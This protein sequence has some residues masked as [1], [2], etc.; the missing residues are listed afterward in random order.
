MQGCV[1]GERC[2]LLN[3]TNNMSDGGASVVKQKALPNRRHKATIQVAGSLKALQHREDALL[4]DSSFR[5]FEGLNSVLS[6]NLI[7][8]ARETTSPC[9]RNISWNG[10]SKS[11]P[12][13]ELLHMFHRQEANDPRDK[14]YAFIGMAWLFEDQVWQ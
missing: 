1:S 6:L 3:R 12:L 13:A 2:C 10:P 11:H 14:V 4:F 5:C 9:T 7:A 8:E